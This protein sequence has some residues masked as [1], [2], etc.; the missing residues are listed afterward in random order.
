MT[1]LSRLG[2]P[3]TTVLVGAVRGYQLIVSP[4]F[5]PT[6]RYYPSCSAYAIGA[7]RRHGPVKGV[8]LSAWRL[9]RCNP[10]SHGGVD[11]VPEHGRWRALT[12]EQAE[13][14]AESAKA[15][16]STSDVPIQHPH[17]RI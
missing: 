5:A 6:C 2:R 12:P 11:P 7:L 15:V 14:R 3:L 1:A 13:V 4:W 17:L 16:P 8:L 9:V 10:W